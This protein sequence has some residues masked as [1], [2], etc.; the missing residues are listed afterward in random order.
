[1]HPG[2]IDPISTPGNSNLRAG[3]DD[4][5]RVA[6]RLKAAVDEG[7]LG[8]D[9][10]DERLTATYAAKTYGELATLTAD[11]PPPAP[12]ARSGLAAVTGD[13]DHLSYPGPYRYR[14]APWRPW[15]TASV[16]TTVIWFLTGLDGHWSS[17]WPV[18]VIVPWG[19]VLT[20][21]TCGWAGWRHR[22]RS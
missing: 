19:L 13:P 2:A 7:R 11:L 16:I 1:M 9:E 3:D 14:W 8:L 6:D 12:Q 22:S 15:L 18:W 10:Y 5:Q 20:A 4:R 21:R 17:F